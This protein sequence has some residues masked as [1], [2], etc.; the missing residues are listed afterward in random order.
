MTVF[1]LV[2]KSYNLFQIYFNISMFILTIYIFI[3]SLSNKKEKL[4]NYIV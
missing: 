3:Q 4:V 2:S 1:F